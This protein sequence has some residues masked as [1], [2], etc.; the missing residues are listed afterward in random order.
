MA[1]WYTYENNEVIGPFEVNE[2]ESKVNPDSLVCRAG[3][4][5]WVKASQ[6]EELSELFEDEQPQPPAEEPTPP[7]KDTEAQE[8]ES[9]QDLPPEPTV[10][11][12]REI[13]QQAS[14]DEL[15]DEY[16]EHW[17][18]YDRKERRIIRN[19]MVNRGLWQEVTESEEEEAEQGLMA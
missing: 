9:A 17:D 16:N 18:S 8:S 2:L 5:D 13:C 15:A 1:K 14:D 10:K 19:E 12:L 11:K 4:E 3:G 7:E 6:V